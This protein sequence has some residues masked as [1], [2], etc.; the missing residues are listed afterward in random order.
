VP[1][2]LAELFLTAGG[3][4]RLNTPVAG[5]DWADNVFVLQVAGQIISA[6]SLI[7]AMPRRS[8][9]LLMPTSPSL[10]AIQDL[11][12]SV[13]PRP[14]FKLFTTYT[15][16][17]WRAAGY[18][19]A[20]GKFVAVEAG[21][22]VTDLPVRQTYYWPQDNGKP[23]TD[24]PAMLMASYDDG[25]NIGFWDGI[26]PRRRQAW[27]AGREVAEPDDPFLNAAS[28]QSSASAWHQYQ[29]PRRMVAEVARQLAIIHGLPYTPE[30]CNAAFR[31][32]GD[33][34]F[35][36]G[37]NSWNIGVKSWEV[38]QRIVKPLDQCSLYI[39]GE[40]YSDA[41]GWV[42]GA[43]QTVDLMLEKFGIA[44]L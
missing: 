18:T 30:V 41:Q 14:L 25:T 22:T 8:L 40:A 32:W 1:K 12:A 35:G 26:R 28:I 27:Q 4:I 19:A 33:D 36:G 43:L 10:Q 7:L 20:D 42:E 16:P 29:A 6:T 9:D 37:W 24:G 21:R 5:F 13:T 38:K 23:V 31:D 11:I 44:P 3:D 34:P 39:C 15:T 17:W 2:A